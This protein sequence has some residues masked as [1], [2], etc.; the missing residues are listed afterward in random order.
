V[1]HKN[2]LAAVCVCLPTCPVSLFST[3]KLVV[4]SSPWWWVIF[5]GHRNQSLST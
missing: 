2:M 1:L 5:M 3:A 4:T